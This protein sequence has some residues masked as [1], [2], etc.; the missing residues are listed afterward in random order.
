MRKAILDLLYQTEA[1]S[2]LISRDGTNVSVALKMKLDSK[3]LLKH[4]LIGT[5][6]K[7]WTKAVCRED[8]RTSKDRT[9]SIVPMKM[10]FYNRTWAIGR[11]GWFRY[12]DYHLACIILIEVFSFLP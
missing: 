8:L 2:E 4:V 5:S 3:K 7:W 10:I 1:M 12:G 11:S 6:V 9:I